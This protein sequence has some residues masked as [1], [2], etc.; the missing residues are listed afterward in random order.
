MRADYRPERHGPI[1]FG[2]LTMASLPKRFIDATRDPDPNLE[3][4]ENENVGTMRR[5]QQ[6]N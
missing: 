6:A 1:T 4:M 3:K 5:L 2:T